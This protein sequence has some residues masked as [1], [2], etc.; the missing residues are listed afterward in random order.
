MELST[1]V[2]IDCLSLLTCSSYYIFNEGSS[3]WW[4]NCFHRVD[5]L[6]L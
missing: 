4:C 3:L 5:D 6:Q 1:Y 2:Y